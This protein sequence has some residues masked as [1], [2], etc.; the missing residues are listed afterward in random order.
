MAGHILVSGADQ[1]LTS[2]GAVMHTG[3]FKISFVWG[4][5]YHAN[6][7]PA[8]PT[9]YLYGWALQAA[10][11]DQCPPSSGSS[12]HAKD[13][14][15]E[16]MRFLARL[17]GSWVSGPRS[18]SFA[19]CPETLLAVSLTEKQH[20]G[21]SLPPSLLPSLLPHWGCIETPCCPAHSANKGWGQVSPLWDDFFFVCNVFCFG[22][23]FLTGRHAPRALGV[24]SHGGLMP[25]GWPA[26]GHHTHPTAPLACFS[27]WE[28]STGLE[29]SY[30]SDHRLVLQTIFPCSR[31]C[32][33]LR[34]V[35]S[36]GELVGE[37]DGRVSS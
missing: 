28:L 15:G 9:C 31:S 23:G 11:T 26:A 1:H 35:S 16:G 3:S 32:R 2:W 25:A 27:S 20:W 5:N 18:R 37:W 36:P 13:E 29:M 22:F 7:H 19:S 21:C 24:G 10:V 6:S 8:V 33:Q 34:E 14:P 30:C 17:F 4:I 12:P